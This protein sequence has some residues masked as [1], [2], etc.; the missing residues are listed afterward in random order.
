MAALKRPFQKRRNQEVMSPNILYNVDNIKQYTV[1][2][3]CIF[4]YY[5]VMVNFLHTGVDPRILPLSVFIL[6]LIILHLY[7][8][9]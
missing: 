1:Y 7:C 4:L 2:E 3:F 5:F 6:A 9:Q 8:I